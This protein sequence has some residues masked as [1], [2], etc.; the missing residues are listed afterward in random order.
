MLQWMHQSVC[1]INGFYI[2]M[3]AKFKRILNEYCDRMS[4]HDVRQEYIQ[5]PHNFNWQDDIGLKIG[6]GYAQF[7]L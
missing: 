1:P 5:D 2:I 4:S 6:A 7:S 3:G